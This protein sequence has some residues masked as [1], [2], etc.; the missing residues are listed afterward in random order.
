MVVGDEAVD[1]GLQVDDA[2]LLVDAED[3]GVS[4]RIDTEADDVADLGGELRIIGQLEG[5]DSVRGQAVGPPDTLHRGEADTGDLGHHPTS[6]VGGLAGRRRQGQSQDPLGDLVGKLGT[7][8]GRVLSRSRP[9][10]PPFMKRSCQRHTAVL[11][12]PAARMISTVLRPSAL[13]STARARRA[14]VGCCGHRRSPAGA[15]DRQGLDGRR[16]RCASR[17]I[18]RPQSQG[19]PA[20]DSYVSIKPLAKPSEPRGSGYSDDGVRVFELSLAPFLFGGRRPLHDGRCSRSPDSLGPSPA[21]LATTWPNAA[22]GVLSSPQVQ[23]QVNSGLRAES[24]ACRRF[25]T[26]GPSLL[27]GSSARGNAHREAKAAAQPPARSC[28]Q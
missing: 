17:R 15:C 22:E 12:T 28:R 18:A 21:L 5:S 7:R 2:R 13:A 11:L 10:T 14:S 27:C 16:H 1:R 19:N 24:P 4:G 8:P 3:D 26:H 25:R 23:N 9:L 20:G 6:P